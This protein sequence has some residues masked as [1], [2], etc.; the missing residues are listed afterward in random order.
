MTGKGAVAAGKVTVRGMAAAG[1]YMNE[2]RQRAQLARMMQ[3][4]SAMA[5]YGAVTTGPVFVSKRPTQFGLPQGLE[6]AVVDTR[7][8]GARPIVYGAETYDQAVEMVNRLMNQPGGGG[9]GGGGGIR[10]GARMAYEGVREFNRNSDFGEPMGYN[11]PGPIVNTQPVRKQVMQ[12]TTTAIPKG[13]KP[14]LQVDTGL[15][16]GPFQID[17]GIRGPIGQRRVKRDVTDIA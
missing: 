1:A 16:N 10:A 9:P 5:E 8:G 2:S 13:F 17:T 6:F 4:N 15:G 7:S 11:V 12:S 14:R 3:P